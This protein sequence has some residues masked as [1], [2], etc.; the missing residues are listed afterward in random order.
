MRK[1]IAT[2]KP[3]VKLTGEDGNAFSIMARCAVAARKAG[4]R[5]ARVDTVMNKMTAGDYNNLLAVAME[6]F[7]V[8]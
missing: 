5:T 3:A 4:W 7:D 8:S 6:N 1:V 2:R